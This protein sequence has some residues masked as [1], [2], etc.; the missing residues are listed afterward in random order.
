MKTPTDDISGI[1]PEVLKEA[2]GMGDGEA[3]T[4]CDGPYNKVVRVNGCKDKCAQPATLQALYGGTDSGAANKCFNDCMSLRIIGKTPIGF[5]DAK[6][7][8][9]DS[10]KSQ[11]VPLCD[12]NEASVACNKCKD[13]CSPGTGTSSGS[14]NTKPKIQ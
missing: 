1:W 12:G 7:W 2:K 11:C 4:Q 8:Q 14:G 9:Q 13:A 5:E 6:Q 3:Y 10:C